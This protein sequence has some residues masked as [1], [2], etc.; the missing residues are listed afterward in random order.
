MNQH[1]QS[2]TRFSHT[3]EKKN[4]PTMNVKKLQNVRQPVS[5]LHFTAMPKNSAKKK[6]WKYLDFAKKKNKWTTI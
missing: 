5:L 1:D 3:S 4:N 6:H 2:D